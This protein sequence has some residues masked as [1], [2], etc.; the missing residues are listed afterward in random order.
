MA[1]QS[2]LLPSSA[3]HNFHTLF[4]SARRQ[5]TAGTGH[6]RE[7]TLDLDGPPLWAHSRL[8]SSDG[9]LFVLGENRA[10]EDLVLRHE[11][12]QPM[13]AV[14]APL[15]G[16]AAA[17]MDDLG[18]AITAHAGE[19]QLFASPSSSSTVHLR[20][21]VKNQAFRVALDAARVRA[22]AE[23][24]A[25][26]EPL[27]RHVENG[28]PF[29]GKPTRPLPLQ[30][31]QA[32]ALEVFDS[33][34]YGAI[35][36]MFLE[37]RALSWLAMALAAPD[38]PNGKSPSAREIARMHEAR[39]L[40]LLRL[41]DPPTLAEVACA[42]GTNDFSLKRNFKAVF[43]QPVYGYLLNL[44]LSQASRLLLDTRLSVKEVATAVGYAHANHFSAAFRRAYGA[45]PAR[46]R[47]NGRALTLNSKRSDGEP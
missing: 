47:G 32:E 15:R 5:V 41:D 35:R 3:G 1:T 22:L 29:C 19:L 12:A 34:R 24:H 21:H 25:E 13:V 31:V 33:E 2:E 36:P 28:S 9:L 43:G 4:R 40:L 7:L 23:R 39:D 6:V 26:L 30:R 14:H 11:G 10:G 38:E 46:Y 42:V 37:A 27:A 20:A 44:R 45:S 8:L 16:S 18:T 17:T